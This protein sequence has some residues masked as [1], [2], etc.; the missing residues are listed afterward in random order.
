MS[1]EGLD[2]GHSPLGREERDALRSSPKV[3]I[4]KEEETGLVHAY[5]KAGVNGAD[6][7]PLK[8]DSMI[9]VVE[10]Y[11]MLAERAVPGSRR[12]KVELPFNTLYYRGNHSVIMNLG[13]NGRNFRSQALGESLPEA[14]ARAFI[15]GCWKILRQEHGIR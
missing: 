15:N 8:N 11:A 5:L 6:R 3:W 9:G 7:E 4:A 12:I 10:T 2:N 1:V 13:F 14:T